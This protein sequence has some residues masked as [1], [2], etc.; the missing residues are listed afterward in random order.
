MRAY[1]D[2]VDINN[3]P[4]WSW[5]SK[6][7]Y[8]ATKDS[9]WNRLILPLIDPTGDYSYTGYTNGTNGRYG[10][11]T[12]GFVE[13]NMPTLANYSWWTDFG[14][15]NNSSGNYNKGSYYGSYRWTQETGYNDSQYRAYRGSASSLFAAAYANNNSPDVGDYRGWLAVL[16]RVDN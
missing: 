1:N 13:N 10:S 3:H 15:N 8:N 9:E 14:G 11:S 12:K 5:N 6:D 4:T 16:E 2:N 7:H